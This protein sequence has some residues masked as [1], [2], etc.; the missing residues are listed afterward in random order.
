VEASVLRHLFGLETY[1]IV[2]LV[3]L[4]LFGAL[5]AALCRRAG[6]RLRHAAALTLLYLVRNFLAAKVVFDYVKAGGR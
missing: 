2:Q 3:A 4:L 5:A 6:L 1:A